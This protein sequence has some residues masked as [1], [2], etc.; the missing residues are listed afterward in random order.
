MVPK[1]VVEG[2]IECEIR[3][4]RGGGGLPV[5]A[6][7]VNG[8]VFDGRR[9]RPGLSVAVRSGLVAA[10][11]ADLRGLR[12]PRTEVVDLAGG[13]LVPG[14]VDAHIHPVQGGLERARCDLSPAW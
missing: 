13:L 6:L 2:G 5:D 7:F 14:F 1:S 11:G 9:H 4:N 8:S 3:T 12:G 10:V